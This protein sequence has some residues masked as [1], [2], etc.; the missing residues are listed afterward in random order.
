MILL[1]LIRITYS[2]AIERVIRL[3][4]APSNRQLHLLP[5]CDNLNYYFR[6]RGYVFVLNGWL[7]CLSVVGEFS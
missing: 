4:V 2:L 6:E 7:G 3:N 1:I 5:S